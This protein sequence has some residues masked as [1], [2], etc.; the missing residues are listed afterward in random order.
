MEGD[1]GSV[2]MNKQGGFRGGRGCVD[3]VFV[4]RQKGKKLAED[5]VA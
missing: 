2:V 4:M 1:N 5:K 3:H